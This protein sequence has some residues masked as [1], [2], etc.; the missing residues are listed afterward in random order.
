V[1]DLQFTRLPLTGRPPRLTKFSRSRGRPADMRR[2]LLTK[3]R[4]VP[5]PRIASQTARL[6][7]RSFGSRDVAAIARVRKSP[8]PGAQLIKGE[9]RNVEAHLGSIYAALV[10]QQYKETQVQFQ[11]ALRS[12]NRLPM[13]VRIQAQAAVR[14]GFD[15]ATKEHS[16]ALR[17]AG[18]RVGKRELSRM[19]KELS[20]RRS[21]Y[22]AFLDM[23]ASAVGGA[24]RAPRT[25]VAEIVPTTVSGLLGR[26]GV[27]SLEVPENWCGFKPIEGSVTKNFSRSFALKSTIKYPCGVKWCRK[28]GVKYPCGVKWCKKTIT[29]AGGSVSFSLDIGYR[30]DCCGGTAWGAGEVKACGTVFNKKL[31]A[32]CEAHVT[33][34]IGAGRVSSTA[35]RCAYGLGAT[36]GASC[37][38]GGYT[39]FS[40]NLSFGWTIEAPCP[41]L[42]LCG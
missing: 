34:V 20:A 38:L 12:A 32:S 35:G 40:G 14:R 22:Q 41:P 26:K 18:L 33:G 4:A 15:Q 9:K 2:K 23:R 36:V 3:I 13:A 8:D 29:W 16:A 27:L 10:A 17:L 25:L 42:G 21:D 24:T 6:K 1:P 5:T 31:C 37:K 11:Q 7:V 39:V 28:F 19:A 30:I